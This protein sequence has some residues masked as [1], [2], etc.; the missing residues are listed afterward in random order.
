[1]HLDG[2]RAHEPVQLLAHEYL[3]EQVLR[4][5]ERKTL[6]ICSSNLL[7]ERQKAIRLLQ[8]VHD[9]EQLFDQ[10][11]TTE[12]TICD[13]DAQIERKD[14]HPVEEDNEVGQSE[15]PAHVLSKRDYF[16]LIWVVA[17]LLIDAFLAHRRVV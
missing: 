8:L 5:Q 6:C 13:T 17:Q 2:L 4:G 10:V 11:E 14:G 12:L 1:M 3:S 16:R 9:F 7:H 15:G